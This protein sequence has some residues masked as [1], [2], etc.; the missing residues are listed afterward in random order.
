[1]LV[2]NPN[3]TVRFTVR[4]VRRSRKFSE[5]RMSRLPAGL[6]NRNTDLRSGRAPLPLAYA[7]VDVRFSRLRGRGF[8]SHRLHCVPKY[9]GV[10]RGSLRPAAAA[11]RRASAKGKRDR[12]AR[13]LAPAVRPERQSTPGTFPAGNA[14]DDPAL[15]L[16]AVVASTNPTSPARP[17]SDNRD[18]FETCTQRSS[19]GSGMPCAGH[20]TTRTATTS[21]A[22]RWPTLRCSAARM[23]FFAGTTVMPR[24]AGGSGVIR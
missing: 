1:V 11:R 6:R 7:L 2:V 14:T 20:G 5:S 12:G 15:P 8:D 4:A 19:T 16:H 18:S 22:G 24:G 13:W 23:R 17:L 10:Q 3:P 9:K 21:S